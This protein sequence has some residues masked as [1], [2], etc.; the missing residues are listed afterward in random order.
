MTVAEQELLDYIFLS[1]C[2]CFFYEGEF[3]LI[4]LGKEKKIER[5]GSKTRMRMSN[6]N[7][8][9]FSSPP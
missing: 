1:L 8:L 9:R 6:P 2:V 7:L 5:K 3:Y 4:Q